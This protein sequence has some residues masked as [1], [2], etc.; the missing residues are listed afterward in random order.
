MHLLFNFRSSR[1]SHSSLEH[2]DSL[3]SGEEDD[4]EDNFET[5]TAE[6]L[7]SNL[8]SRVSILANTHKHKLLLSLLA[9]PC[10]NEQCCSVFQHH[11]L[12]HRTIMMLNRRG[13]CRICQLPSL[14]ARSIAC[15]ID[16]RC[17][18][19]RFAASPRG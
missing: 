10:P 15:Y 3:S 13:Q 7:F 18:F 14:C 4:D 2:N 5:L 11:F 19:V 16:N 17:P 8:L 9:G 1:P 12:I 6:S